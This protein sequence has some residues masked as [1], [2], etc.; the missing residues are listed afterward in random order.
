MSRDGANGGQ[1]LCSSATQPANRCSVLGSE[2]RKKCRKLSHHAEEASCVQ[3]KL[4]C[5]TPP[6]RIVDRGAS[7]PPLRRAPIRDRAGD[8]TFSLALDEREAPW[9]SLDQSWRPS[10]YHAM[11]VG[12]SDFEM[13]LCFTSDLQCSFSLSLS[14]SLCLFLFL[15]DA[16]QGCMLP[17]D[18]SV[19][20]DWSGPPAGSQ[21]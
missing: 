21:A 14:F 16:G 19:G 18:P 20:G 6:P 5:S 3:A 2:P 11:C 9:K 15:A 7:P 13:S 10:P 1:P 4:R 17:A 12:H 8:V